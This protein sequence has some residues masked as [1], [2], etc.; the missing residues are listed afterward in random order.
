MKGYNLDLFSKSTEPHYRYTTPQLVK[1]S[2]KVDDDVLT[3]YSYMGLQKSVKPEE[4][5]EAFFREIQACDWAYES[6]SSALDLVA[7]DIHKWY[8]VKF[9]PK[10]ISSLVVKSGDQPDG[11]Q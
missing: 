6:V 3:K 8:S 7:K 2:I 5:N 11:P 9:T 1:S 10:T 4:K